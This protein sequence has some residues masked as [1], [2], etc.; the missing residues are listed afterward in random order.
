MIEDENTTP[1]DAMTP[2]DKCEETIYNEEEDSELN[3]NSSL[4]LNNLKNFS[5]K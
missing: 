1:E 5:P 4:M 3:N 2:L